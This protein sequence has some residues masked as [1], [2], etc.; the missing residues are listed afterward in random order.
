MTVPERS[1]PTTDYASD[2]AG[3]DI[4]LSSST[5]TGDTVVNPAGDKLGKLEDIM[6]DIHTG[7]IAYAV[8]G[9]GGFLGMGEKLFAVPWAALSV[10]TENRQ[11]VIDIERDV[12][13]DAPGFDPDNWP[14]FADREWAATV[15]RH[16]A[17]DPYW[18]ADRYRADS[19]LDADETGPEPLT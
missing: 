9:F 8:I 4:I 12:L 18:T 13:K 7:S 17:A 15:H 11:L 14:T 1:T 19:S 5:L 16:Y 2:P 6:L 3:T 10:D